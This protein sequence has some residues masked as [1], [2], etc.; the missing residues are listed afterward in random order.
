MGEWSASTS[1]YKMAFEHTWNKG[2]LSNQ[3]IHLKLLHYQASC[4]STTGV[5][6]TLL[7]IGRELNLRL[8][9]LRPS[10]TLRPPWDG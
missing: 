1:L 8:N 7:M 3:A 10:A 6:P 4:H 2:E 9:R 5:P